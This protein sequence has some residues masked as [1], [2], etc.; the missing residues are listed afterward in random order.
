MRAWLMVFTTVVLAAS[1]QA[2]T[3]AEAPEW[4]RTLEGKFASNTTFS[5]LIQLRTPERSAESAQDVPAR[6]RAAVSA[7]TTPVVQDLKSSGIDV[8]ATY[9]YQPIVLAN[10]QRDDLNT[11]AERPEVAAVYENSYIM[12][13]PLPLQPEPLYPASEEPEHPQLDKS[14]K[15]I[16]ADAAW[17]R[18]YRGQGTAVAVLDTGINASHEMFR[19][20]IVAEACFSDGTISTNYESLCP[21]QKKSVIGPGAASL[22]PGAKADTNNSCQHGSHVAGIAVGDNNSPFTR[23]R[24]VAPEA[25]IVA[26]QVFSRSK[27]CDSC[28]GAYTSDL[29]AALDWVASVAATHNIAAVNL[30]LGSSTVYSSAC[31]GVP[32]ENAVKVLRQ[33]NVLTVVAAGNESYKGALSHPACIRDTFSVGSVN[34]LGLPSYFSNTSSALDVFAPGESIKSAA[35]GSS[36]SYVTMSGTSMATPHIAGAI[37]VLKSKMPTATAAQL[38][39]AIQGSGPKVTKSDWTWAT[40]RLDLNAALDVLGINPPPPG[41]TMAGLFP[42]DRPDVRSVLRIVHTGFDTITIPITVI[43]DTPRLV[44]GTYKMTVN[45]KG[46]AQAS[47]RDMENAIRAQASP[48]SLVTLLINAPVQIYAQHVVIDSSGQSIS[49][50]TQCTSDR[51]DPGNMLTFVQTQAIANSVSYITFVNTS[52]LPTTPTFYLYNAGVFNPVLGSSLGT[53]RS[54]TIAGNSTV[55]VSAQSIFDKASALGSTGIPANVLYVNM[56]VTDFTGVMRHHV[57]LPQARVISDMTPK[58]AI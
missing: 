45:G 5:V 58:C 28:L 33:M 10:V 40:P 44:L 38:E 2:Q 55:R 30:S 47:V 43:Q 39:Y 31:V 34:L 56:L 6:T 1:A 51:S 32:L 27:G 20:R 13:D 37:A 19:G 9:T 3:P 57:E 53:A 8:R 35:F 4:Q 12:L 54:L 21:E 25:G 11:L 36:A 7:A 15:S 14:T 46:S 48:T 50:V 23:L 49:N 17:A 22:C 16:N 24:G 52:P 26:V 42:G 29:L 41:V 18:G